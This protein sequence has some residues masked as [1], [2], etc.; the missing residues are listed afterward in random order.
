VIGRDQI[1]IGLSPTCLRVAACKGGRP[2]T[3]NCTPLEPGEWEKT[4]EQGLTP[5]DEKLAQALKALK[6][7]KGAT[8]RVVYY[9]S[10]ATAEVFSV[11][12]RGNA[13]IQ[14]A[15]F[16]LTE[17]LPDRGADWPSS[18]TP[19]AADSRGAA[20]PK[21]H[22]LGVADSPRATETLGE[23]LERA[24]V[25]LESLIPA[26]AAAIARAV[27]AVKSLPS[28]EPHAMLWVEDH[29]TVFVGV[30]GGN[31]IFA[32]GLDFGYAKLAEAIA[33]AGRA[34]DRRGVDQ[35][36]AY[37]TLFAAGIPQRHQGPE[38]G[39]TGVCLDGVLPLMQPVLQRFIIE[40][41]QTLRFSVAEAEH[42]KLKVL[43]AGSGATIPGLPEALESN[44]DAGIQTHQSEDKC[45]LGPMEAGEL[46]C[47][48]GLPFSGVLPPSEADRRMHGRLN[49]ALR[50]GGIVLAMVMLASGG[51][52]YA[53][54]AALRKQVA[55]FQTRVDAMDEHE[56]Y[57]KR[58]QKL[59]TDIAS[60]SQTIKDL[61]G[62]RPRWFAALAL[63]SR[64]CG[65]SV[66]LNHIAGS[67]A[68]DKTPL[69]T[70][71]GTAY[72]KRNGPD[73][74]TDF[75]S[76]VSKNPVV[77]N[78]KIVSTQATEVSGVEAKSFIV[79]VHL[80]AADAETGFAGVLDQ[81]RDFIAG[82]E[83]KP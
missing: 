82:V 60:A 61:I 42:S 32:R 17:S 43:I 53:R 75:V 64:D 58:A 16:S 6:V 1:L 15:A 35:L 41:R 56:L 22:I 52:A 10:A 48:T 63:V 18:L 78:V 59:S 24:G 9:S 29:V 73:S 51:W 13:A 68:P 49:G 7:G 4:W 76:R 23:W 38:A 11:P 3:V 34:G 33:R 55:N 46:S 74:L 5:L 44:F 8:A 27:A 19:L 2:S 54:T 79:S 39:S 50:V 83:D 45:P 25:T 37:Q 12:V 77:A 71:S 67:Y 66:E 20:S 80:R 70:L 62:E 72:P 36:L 65:D 81:H 57:V 26:K 30:S 14:A 69:L 21:T 40:T 28:G 47:V 31:L